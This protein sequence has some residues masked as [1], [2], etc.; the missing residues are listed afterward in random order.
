MRIYKDLIIRN[1]VTQTLMEHLADCLQKEQR[2][3]KHEQMIELITILF[4]QLICIPDASIKHTTDINF[5][6]LQKRLLLH[7]AETS[8][9]D[10]FIYLTQDFNQDI[11]KKLSPVF[12]EIWYQIFKSFTPQQIFTPEEGEKNAQ[13]EIVAREKARERRL[14]FL[15]GIRHSKFGS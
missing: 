1:N 11:Q 15:R 8:V 3:E 6:T 9:L 7:F 14:N 2:T 4:K 5:L 12:L 13:E 10:S